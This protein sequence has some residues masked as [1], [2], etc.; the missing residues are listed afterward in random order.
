MSCSAEIYIDDKFVGYTPI[1]LFIP[2]GDHNYK[3]VKSEYFP[4]PPPPPSSSPL[5]TG[6]IHA[7]N[8]LKYSLDINLVNNTITGGIST[9][10]TPDGAK[11]FIDDKEQ[12]RTTPTAV[13]GLTIGEHKYRMTL[14]GYADAEGTFTTLLGEPVHVHPIFK[15]LEDYGT[16]FIY[17]TTVLYGIT[18]PY[19]LQ[20]AK[21]YIDNVD[22]GKLLPSA[23]TGLTKGVHTFRVEKPG[24]VDR[25][26]MFVINGGDTL[27]ISVYPILQPKT[28]ILIM[29]VAPFVGDAKIAHV[30]IDDKDTGYD[31]EIRYTLPE[32]T[33]TY[34]LTLP[35]H[36]DAEDK[37]D[38]VEKLVTRTTAYMRRIGSPIK[39]RVNIS[40]NPS[41]ALIAIDS[42][43]IGQYT[44]TMV[45]HLSDGDY[46]YILSKPG[47]SDITGTFTI[48]GGNTMNLNPSLVQKD[49]I[50]EISCS[51][52]AAMVYI[53]DHT[54]GWTTPAVIVGL[55]PGSHTYRLV[56]P[57]T[58]GKAF[59][60]ATGTFN[61]NKEK[62]TRV[63]ATMSPTK[64]SAGNL[65]INSA[66][67]G[68]I[69]SIDDVNT[70][71]ATP[72]NTI[73]ISPG[74]HK[75][76]LTSSGYK[77]WL[78]TVSIISGSVV[79]MLQSLIP[80]KM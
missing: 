12:K 8:G 75:V 47:Y 76:K 41:G 35:D 46:T 58:Y 2:E 43:Y 77:D 65:V 68:A 9:D 24:T 73:G 52:V 40:S 54:E 79:S 11:L 36:E 25:E 1:Q 70:K 27:L 67:T 20:G 33:H 6:T 38:I 18:A 32:G 13:P 15:Q 78:G 22:T 19:I 21:I 37:F 5:M 16:L 60:D 57:E 4:L 51:T 48:T 23:V 30:Y 3:I 62:I 55:P 10:S 34:R 14:P 39:G 56:I 61:L 7:E 80:E 44:P 28:G 42:V 17:P 49:T 72:Y 31:T 59:E 53:D 26:G 45:G 74:I 66:P 63:Y 71:S 69:V 29:H 64:E 50:L